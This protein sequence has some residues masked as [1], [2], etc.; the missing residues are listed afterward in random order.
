MIPSFM[1][2]FRE[3]L[4]AF[5]I[6]GIIL[7]Y[8]AQTKRTELN[9]HVYAATGLAVLG[10]I[11]AALVFNSLAIEFAGKNEELFEGIVMLI[12]A[13]VLT[14]MIIWMARESKNISSSIRQKVDSNHA[15]GLFVLAFVSVF[16]EG[17]ETV[18]FLGA[19]AMNTEARTV[20]YGGVLGLAT[21]IVVAYLV[22]KSSSRVNLKTFFKYTGIF[23]ILF[24]AGLTAHGVHELQE[25][26]VVPIIVEH[27]WDMNHLLD[28]N[29]T[30][31][32]LLKSLF[33]YNG[34]PS[35]LEVFAY[36]GYYV[37]V[38]LGLKQMSVRNLPHPETA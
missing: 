14:S 19:A 2:T 31:G 36:V 35:L 12:A 15:R 23:L 10:S 33:G 25:A 26:G 24:A 7:A 32:S 8:L 5:L 27:V 28:E 3:G 38:G 17:I 20:L 1:I 34:N 22:F 6:V 16:R 4:E 11:G 37:A 9:K 30:V 21:S 13:A 18:L 29:G